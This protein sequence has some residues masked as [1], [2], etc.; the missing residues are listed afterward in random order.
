[1]GIWFAFA[2]TSFVFGEP[3]KF[4]AGFNYVVSIVSGKLQAEV[5]YVVPREC[6]ASFKKML[7]T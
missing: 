4:Q 1:M 5:N 3:G 6:L 7:R 2:P